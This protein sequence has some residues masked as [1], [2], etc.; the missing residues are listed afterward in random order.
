MTMYVSV[1]I[2]W[3]HDERWKRMKQNGKRWKWKKIKKIKIKFDKQTKVL[4]VL[5]NARRGA[6]KTEKFKDKM[7]EWQKS[8]EILK[9]TKNPWL[10]KWIII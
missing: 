6:E 7:T 10:K 8:L 2:L 5:S 3:S 9:N 4:L 1:V